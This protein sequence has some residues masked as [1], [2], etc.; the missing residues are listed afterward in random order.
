MHSIR[1]IPKDVLGQAYLK[2]GFE[3]RYRQG[4]SETKLVIASSVDNDAAKEALAGYR[5]FMMENGKV[6]RDLASPG[7]GGFV[8]EDSYYGN[9]AAIVS[10]DRIIIALG[11]P[12][13][14]FAISQITACLRKR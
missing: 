10:G 1:Y 3:A 13:A 14:D 6:L 7:D 12:S 8:G 5:Q 4:S 2:E 11:G 9:M